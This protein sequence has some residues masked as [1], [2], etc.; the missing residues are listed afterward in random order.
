M[1]NSTH[2]ETFVANGMTE[3]WVFFLWILPVILML[4]ALILKAFHKFFHNYCPCGHLSSE[5]NEE[6]IMEIEQVKVNLV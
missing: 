4:T 1:S 2:N 6:D 5:K 3:F